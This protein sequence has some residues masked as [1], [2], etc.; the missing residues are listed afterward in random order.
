M[1]DEKSFRDLEAACDFRGAARAALVAGALGHAARLAALADD[2]GTL[3]EAVDALVDHAKDEQIAA[4]AEDLLSRGFGAPA[5]ALFEA[6]KQTLR[7]A[8]AFAS[9]GDA[10]RASTA[11]ERADRLGDAAHVLERAIRDEPGDERAR[12]ALAKLLARHGRTEAAVKTI[13]AMRVGS[14]ERRQALPLLARS[15]RAI[16]LPEAAA[17]IEREIGDVG[18]PVGDDI[19]AGEVPEREARGE[20][21]FGRFEIAREVART[22][23]ARV[24]LTSDRIT[25]NPVAVKV[26]NATAM[27]TGRDALLRFE[28]EARALGKIHHANIVPLLGYY[29]DGPAMALEWMSGGS[30][31]EMLVREALAPARAAE[32]AIAVLGALGEAHRLGILHR[33]VKPANVLFDGIGSPRL[34]DFGAAHLSDASVTATAAAIGTLIYM[35]PEQ[36]LGRPATVASDLYAVGALLFEM[37][38]GEVPVPLEEGTFTGGSRRIEAP[39]RHNED[40]SATHDAVVGRLLAEAPDRRPHDAFEAR[41][42]VESVKWPTRVVAHAAPASVRT[43]S[44]APP[45]ERLGPPRE[46]GDGRDAENLRFDAWFERHVIVLPADE[47]TLLLARAFAAD[48]A[49]EL[50]AVLRVFPIEGQVWLDRPRGVAWADGAAVTAAMVARLIEA[51]RRIHARGVGHGA[52]DRDHVYFLDG[53]AT[54]AFPRGSPAAD[55]IASDERAFKAWIDPA[56]RGR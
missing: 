39:S 23:N 24:V 15:L 37:L 16:G 4:V 30:L 14:P 43:R 50:P 34:A 44:S 19:S 5:G 54:L 41:K 46:T 10:L 53:E 7:A 49:P 32:I 22:P 11:Y 8:E 3:A 48:G 55:A 1:A 26:F 56:G 17:E 12:L 51:M 42:L 35:S 52:L 31:S 27:G 40:L 29:E 33:D 47:P 9:G 28:R 18:I 36:R 6:A 25:G 20:V 45:N 2:R 13:Q 21:L 38:T